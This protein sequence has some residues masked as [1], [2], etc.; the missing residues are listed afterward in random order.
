MKTVFTD[1]QSHS[2]DGTVVRNRMQLAALLESFSNRTPFGC[3][4]VADNGHKVVFGAGGGIGFVQH[5]PS[6]GD[7]PFRMAIAKKNHCERDYVE[8]LVGGTATPIAQRYCLSASEV[9]EIVACF[10]ETGELAL[11]FAWEEI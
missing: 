2:G 3:E 11:G 10:V 9:E 1:L 5:S 6:D 8:F 7:P 4:L